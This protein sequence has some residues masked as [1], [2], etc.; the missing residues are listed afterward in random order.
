MTKIGCAQ[1][2]C[3][4]LYDVK[5][6]MTRTD[7]WYFKCN[8]EN[9][10]TY[11]TD[12]DAYLAGAPCT[13]CASG[14]GWCDQGLCDES[15]TSTNDSCTCEWVSACNSH[16]A[17]DQDT[18]R[19]ICEDGW[20]G[21][22]CDNEPQTTT[23]LVTN[24]DD[25]TSTTMNQS[26]DSSVATY[27]RTNIEI[28]ILN[29]PCATNN[30]GCDQVCRVSGFSNRIVCSCWPGYKPDERYTYYIVCVKKAA[31]ANVECEHVCT[32]IG[33]SEHE[34]SC[35]AS[36]I[37]FYDQHSCVLD[38]CSFGTYCSMNG[39]LDEDKCTCHC[40][41]GYTGELCNIMCDVDDTEC[42]KDYE[43]SPVIYYD[44]NV[45]PVFRVSIGCDQEFNCENGGYL[46]KES[47]F[48]EVSGMCRCYCPFPW[49]GSSCE[50]C[51]L[52]CDHGTMDFENCTCS[53]NDGYNGPE[54]STRCRQTSLLCTRHTHRKCSNDL[55]R[56]LCPVM[57][58]DCDGSGLMD[59]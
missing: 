16:G 11:H 19:C 44:K 49:S 31:C 33:P 28:R 27:S 10:G 22:N 5:S 26:N 36:Y 48:E 24:L 58:G 39:L 9:V 35:Y 14:S 50:D 47:G 17:L 8:Y 13:A 45:C 23:E 56:R 59:I 42:W 43:P 40:F 20:S 32:D 21:H 1:T 57:C 52:T 2:Y 29:N 30:G 37:L 3:P 4:D 54:C 12:V 15:C 6:N 46:E 38:V 7:V 51:N 41:S 34:C 18:C 25:E 53:C 55:I